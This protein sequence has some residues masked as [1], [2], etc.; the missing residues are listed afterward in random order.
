MTA[1]QRQI[2]AEFFAI[3]IEQPA[4]VVNFLFRHA[5][6]D[7]SGGRELIGQPFGESVI[8]A[9]ILFLVRDRERQNL[10]LRQIRKLF[11]YCLVSRNVLKFWQEGRYDARNLEPAIVKSTCFGNDP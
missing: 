4:S 11:H 9:A 3:K 1:D 8:D 7:G 10:A 5:G 2:V 6:Q